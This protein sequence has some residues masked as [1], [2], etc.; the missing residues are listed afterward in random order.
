MQLELIPFSEGMRRRREKLEPQGHHPGRLP[1]TEGHHLLPTL[2]LVAS[3]TD[4]VHGDALTRFHR[5]ALHPV[6][7]EP[8]HPRAIPAG[9]DHDLGSDL[10][11][12]PQR[13][14][15]HHRSGA[16]QAEN[17]IHSFAKRP[18]IHLPRAGRTRLGDQHAAKLVETTAR[19]RGHRHDRCIGK[20]SRGE[21]LLELFGGK[22]GQFV[23]HHVD[24]RQGHGSAGNTHES[25]HLE[26]L[27]G[28][29]HDP[30]I[31]GNHEQGEVDPGGAGDH[32]V[33][34]TLVARDIDEVELH[35]VGGDLGKPEVDGDA[36]IP[37]FGQSI[38]IG[39]GQG[40]H[41]GRLAVIDV[42]GGSKDNMLHPA[43]VHSFLPSPQIG[44]SDHL[45][46]RVRP[47]K[48]TG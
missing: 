22:L 39:P 45:A 6:D 38:A 27:A 32:G 5:L 47:A 34:Q 9:H 28:L 14:S 2:D 42:A 31:R 25:D 12:S 11:T 15:G 20:R 30:L 21:E 3:E 36:S 29:G 46:R 26:V 43:M 19:D 10:E 7:V 40:L 23:V 37:F 18:V 1:V 16:G 33:N 13:C 17:P 8:A 48:L 44:L 41:E 4:Q 24:L 35:V